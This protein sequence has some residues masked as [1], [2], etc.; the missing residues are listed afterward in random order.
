MQV[1]S[2]RSEDANSRKGSAIALLRVGLRLRNRQLNM[3]RKKRYPGCAWHGKWC[4]KVKKHDT[5]AKQETLGYQVARCA[6]GEQELLDLTE[7]FPM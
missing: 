2:R 1:H 5:Q 4:A 6:F 7:M 3:Q